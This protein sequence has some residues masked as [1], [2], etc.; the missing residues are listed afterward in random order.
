MDGN[1]FIDFLSGCGVLNMGHNNPDILGE[2]KKS[3]DIIMHILDFPTKIKIDFME[4]LLSSLP[5]PSPAFGGARQQSPKIRILKIGGIFWLKF[6]LI[7]EKTPT[8]IF[9]P[10]PAAAGRTKPDGSRAKNFLPLNPSIF[11]PLAEILSYTGVPE[12]FE[13]LLKIK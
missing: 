1:I 2:I 8:L 5:K 3:S 7:L 13:L 9:S 11:C 12:E 4:Q 10:P 6:E